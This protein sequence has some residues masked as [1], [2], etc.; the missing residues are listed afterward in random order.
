MM[1]DGEAEID[2][3]S[4]DPRRFGPWMTTEY[5]A[6]KNEEAYSHVFVLHH[7]DE[8]R[9]ACRPLRTAP[10]YDRMKA[11]GAQFG[12]VNG[13]ER[14]NYYRS[15][16]LRR[17]CEPLLPPRRLVALC[18]RGG[19]RHPRERRHDR[20]LGLRQARPQGP[21]ATAFLDWFTCNRLP[22]TGRISLTYALTDAGTVRTEYT[23]A[24]VAERHLLPRLRRR[25]GG[26]RP[27]LPEQGGRGQA[28]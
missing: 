23:I 1:V 26:L 15:A 16:R 7:P 11:R 5:A 21:G 19:P 14:P 22:K 28:A 3:A 8:E 17:P 4:L 6:R 20:R 27:R 12:G 2:M 24:R 9:E 10:C 25:L 18:R 13:W